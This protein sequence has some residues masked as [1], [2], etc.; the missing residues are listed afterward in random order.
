MEVDTIGWISIVIVLGIFTLIIWFFLRKFFKKPIIT[1][2]TE[3]EPKKD[4]R[5]EPVA[6]KSKKSA[7][8]V[9]LVLLLIFAMIVY[10]AN[11]GKWRSVR[12]IPT[13]IQAK[14]RPLA[15][16][17]RIPAAATQNLD[18]FWEVPVLA[19]K[20]IVDSTLQVKKGQK[21]IIIATGKV[22]SCRSRHDR[23]Y[24]WTGPEGRKWSWNKKRKRPLGQ[25]APFMALCAK[26]GQ[27]G[28]WFYV[29][30]GKRFL[31]H[32]NGNIYFTVND[33]THDRHGRFQPGWR[34][35]NEGR[36]IVKAKINKST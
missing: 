13:G 23:A 7:T 1:P 5:K 21:I 34:E 15:G 16:T 26:I 10:W 33:D 36:F 27:D 24:G 28:K 8:I 29:G 31:A 17:F 19:N 20:L 12:P 2:K 18:R 11:T 25:N 14:S 4:E 22:N 6:P 9:L 32:Q 3:T 35:D 30:K